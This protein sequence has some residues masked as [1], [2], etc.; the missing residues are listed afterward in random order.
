[1]TKKAYI[2]PATSTYHVIMPTLL[3]ASGNS[4]SVD[5]DKVIGDGGYDDE[6]LD[7]DAKAN[8]W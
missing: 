2:T 3:N 1:M 7:A 8:F 4:G 6:G 5:G